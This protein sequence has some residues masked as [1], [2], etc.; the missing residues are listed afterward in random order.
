MKVITNH[1]RNDLYDSDITPLIKSHRKRKQMHNVS[2]FSISFCN[3]YL[4]LYS[5]QGS[6]CCL[7]SKVCVNMEINLGV[8][9]MLKLLNKICYTLATHFHR[10]S[11][12]V[13]DKRKDNNSD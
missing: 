7:K 6:Y 13:V 10:L 12:P 9:Y 1:A 5:V 8:I 4:V 3:L 11:Q 2:C